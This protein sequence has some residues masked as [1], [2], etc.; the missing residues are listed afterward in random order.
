MKFRNWPLLPLT[1]SEMP[2]CVGEMPFESS[3]MNYISFFGGKGGSI[4]LPQVLQCRKY[5]VH[6]S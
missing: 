6:A 4:S 5:I 2:H 3:Y 1:V